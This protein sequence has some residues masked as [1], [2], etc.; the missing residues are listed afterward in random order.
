[1]QAI[2]RGGNALV[3]HIQQSTKIPVL[4][5]ADG[6]CHIYVDSGANIETAVR[7]V[8]D[9]KVD[10][11]AACNAVEKVLVH[12]DLAMDGRLFRLQVCSGPPGPLGVAVDARLRGREGGR[13]K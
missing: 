12:E 8:T 2:P 10:Y 1:V 4:G 11:P 9:A 6:I 5:H 3:K 7:V 13:G